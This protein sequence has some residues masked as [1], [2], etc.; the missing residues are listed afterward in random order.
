MLRSSM[1]F[2]TL[3]TNDVSDQVIGAA[4]KVHRHFGPGLLESAYRHC[5]RWELESRGVPVEAEVPIN[6][7]YKGRVVEAAYRLDL[8][9]DGRLIVELKAVDKLNPVHQ[10]QMITY[11][12]VTGLHAG[13]LIN[14]NVEMLKNGIRRVLL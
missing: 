5:L 10:A 11:L 6:V 9:V 13:L 12:K 2:L 7:D 4:I 1:S 3:P 14:F 8:L